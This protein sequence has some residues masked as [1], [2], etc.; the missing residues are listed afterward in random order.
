MLG[1]RPGNTVEE[2][3]AL[4]EEIITCA[5]MFFDFVNEPG[6]KEKRLEMAS[7]GNDRLYLRAYSELIVYLRHLFSC[8]EIGRAHV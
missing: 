7:Q 4:I 1:A 3:N 5:N 6:Q 2:S 8:Y